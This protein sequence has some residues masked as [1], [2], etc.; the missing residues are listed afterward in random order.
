MPGG[1]RGRGG[2]GASGASQVGQDSAGPK[3]QPRSC[4]QIQC[5]FRD[6]MQVASAPAADL[7]TRATNPTCGSCERAGTKA[8]NVTISTAWALKI[9]TLPGNAMR[10][11]W[12]QRVRRSEPAAASR[13]DGQEGG[14]RKTCR[15]AGHP[16]VEGSGGGGG[17]S[18]RGCR[19]FKPKAAGCHNHN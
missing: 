2:G 5:G 1:C 10:P 18:L 12:G 16:F 3:A 19:Q 8:A 11:L 14:H 9:P 15:S 17:F 7:Q 6:G 13:G 4:P